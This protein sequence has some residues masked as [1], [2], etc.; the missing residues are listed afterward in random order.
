MKNGT[1]GLLEPSAPKPTGCVVDS[2]GTS[3]AVYLLVK[4]RIDIEKEIE[5]AKGR[6]AKAS[7]AVEKQVKIIEGNEFGKRPEQAR[8]NERVRLEERRAEVE[9]LEGSV[10]QFERL[11]LE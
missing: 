5:K 6:L 9:V 10:A 7:E 2:I 11:K 3:A 1:V 4:G 8:E